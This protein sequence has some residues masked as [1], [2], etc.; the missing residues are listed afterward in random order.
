M[1]YKKRHV[2]EKMKKRKYDNLVTTT[3]K[4][5]WNVKINAFKS[6]YITLNYLL[7]LRQNTKIDINQFNFKFSS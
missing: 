4:M 6:D 7:F 5:S 3:G 2:G 1:E